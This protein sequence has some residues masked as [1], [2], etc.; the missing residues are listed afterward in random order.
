MFYSC[1]AYVMLRQSSFST[2]LN[3]DYRQR[4]D[5]IRISALHFPDIGLDNREDG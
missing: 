5:Y 4:T 3:I 1:I 2:S